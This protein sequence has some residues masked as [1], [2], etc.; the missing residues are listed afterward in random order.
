MFQTTSLH[1]DLA[2]TDHAL[3]ED[4]EVKC[5]MKHAV[6]WVRTSNPVIRSPSRYLWTTVL[7]LKLWQNIQVELIYV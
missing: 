5:M 1:I 2:T 4:N 3:T 6:D 7:A